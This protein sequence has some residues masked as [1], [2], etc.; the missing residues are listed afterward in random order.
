[1]AMSEL[2]LVWLGTV[3][4]ATSAAMFLPR[5]RVDAFTAMV[6]PFVAAFLWFVV[7]FGS[8]DVIVTDSDPLQS[9]EVMPLF[10][11]AGSFGVLSALVGIYAVVKRPAED[12][13]E[14]TGGLDL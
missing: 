14:R 1:M 6:L 12:I 2:I 9:I 4:T 3:A 13:D 7:A 10:W 5:E 11:L 8:L